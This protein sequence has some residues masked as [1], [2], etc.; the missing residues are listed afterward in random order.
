MGVYL[1]ITKEDEFFIFELNGLNREQIINLTSLNLKLNYKTEVSSLDE[2]E[3][4]S[5]IE[6]DIMDDY[7]EVWDGLIDW[8][9]II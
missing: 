7:W 8:T 4:Y 9:Q 1:K 2:L 3:N 6:R 5:S